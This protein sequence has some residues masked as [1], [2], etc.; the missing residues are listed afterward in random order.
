MQEQPIRRDL[1]TTSEVAK[2]LNRSPDRVR[3]LARMGRLVPAVITSHGQL[4][5][6]AEVER[7]KRERDRCEQIDVIEPVGA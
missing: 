4:F 3:Q 1:L 7:L 5:T 2:R 6:E